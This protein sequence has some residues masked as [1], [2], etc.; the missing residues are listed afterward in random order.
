MNAC[1]ESISDISIDRSGKMRISLCSALIGFVG[2]IVGSLI[3]TVTKIIIANLEQKDRFRLVALEKRLQVHQE[4][5]KLWLEMFGSLHDNKINEIAW[6]CEEWWNGNCLYLDSKTREAF[7][8]AFLQAPHISK[9][10][11]K[12]LKKELFK[13]IQT[14]GELIQQGVDLCVIKEQA[15]TVSDEQHTSYCCY[16]SVL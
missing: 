13:K 2:V 9:L 10:D 15:G 1:N 14:V 7:R 16:I 3:S 12:K 5:Y 4:A 8:E 6:K 11:D